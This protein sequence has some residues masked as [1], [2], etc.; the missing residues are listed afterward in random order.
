MREYRFLLSGIDECLQ[1]FFCAL[2]TLE[3]SKI[4]LPGFLKKCCI[5]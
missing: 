1:G 5:L 3:E 4:E 2:L